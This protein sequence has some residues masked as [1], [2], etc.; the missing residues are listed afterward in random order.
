MQPMTPQVT[1][2]SGGSKT[3]LIGCVI[4]AV[5]LLVCLAVWASVFV[6]MG[7]DNVLALLGL[8]PKAQAA[9]FAP[10]NTPLFIAVNV[11]VQQAVNAQKVLSAFESTPR[12]TQATNDSKKQFRD[13]V[14]CDFDTDIAPWW[15]PEV[16]LFL[17]DMEGIA[18]SPSSNRS[19]PTPTPNLVVA[20]GSHDQA[21]A[22]AAIQKCVPK[23]QTAKTETYKN[24]NLKIY[25]DFVV[26]TVANYVLV[27]TTTKAM[28]AAIDA[29]ANNANS[30]A[31]LSKFKT[32]TANLPANRTATY[33][34]DI[35]PMLKSTFTSQTSVQPQQVLAQLEAYQ[36]LA[37][38]VAFV[39][40][41]IKVDAVVTFDSA[42]MPECTRNLLKQQTAPTA[43][44]N[45]LPANTIG[46]FTARDW[47]GSW[48]CSISAMDATSRK[49]VQDSFDMFPKMYGFDLSA[50][51]LSWMTGEYAV[52]V[53]SAK[54]IANNLPGLGVFM[55]VEAKDQSGISAK[56][57]KIVAALAKQGVPALKEQ[58]IKGTTMKTTKLG[59]PNDATAPAAGY[60]FANGF[61]VLGGPTDA[62]E[63][64][65][66]APNNP[67]S[68]DPT[69]VTVQNGIGKK[70]GGLFY[71]NIASAQSIYANA[72]S[73]RERA[74]FESD[75]LPFI[76]P[77]KAMG[78]SSEMGKDDMATST[79]FIYIGK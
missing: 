79:A 36:A 37:G 32:T 15:G 44:L 64:A 34:V 68:K 25:K 45:A 30:L 9:M 78:F 19:A 28:Y 11:D 39:E 42:K 73:G 38:S 49:Q 72:L 5:L 53:T 58:T 33:Y 54:P 69:F 1:P 59:A 4:L 2:K 56:L 67:L 76:R 52:V 22:N 12:T 60:G 61:L 55:L 31:N 63:A 66:D 17:T 13:N 70:N 26:G 10:A 6:M 50:D 74:T 35:A 41:G 3:V 46:V 43:V 47:K 71:L 48:E 62:L 24:V 77:I 21:K 18:T 57:D 29:H 7:P 27:S 40:N 65:V 75:V 14:G 8:A 20:I 23:D 51:V 16:A